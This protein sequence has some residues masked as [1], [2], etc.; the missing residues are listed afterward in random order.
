M[1]SKNYIL[2]ELDLQQNHLGDL[3]VRLL[4]EGLRKSNRRLGH[5][6]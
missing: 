4:W 2:L 3:G 6:R 1:L 5:L